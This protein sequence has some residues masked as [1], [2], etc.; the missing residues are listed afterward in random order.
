[1]N[2][3]THDIEEYKKEVAKQSGINIQPNDMV[4]LMAASDPCL[5]N[6]KNLVDIVPKQLDPIVL[7]VLGQM[8]KAAME[9]G[10]E[11]VKYWRDLDQ[12]RGYWEVE[13]TSA[14]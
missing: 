10:K 6:N 14:V 4:K 13:P 8:H 1:M 5:F 2:R 12:Y 9:H 3:D 11:Q 7:F